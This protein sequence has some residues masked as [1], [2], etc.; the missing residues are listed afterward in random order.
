[1]GTCQV[2]AAVARSCAVVYA[3]YTGRECMH[4]VL[5]GCDNKHSKLFACWMQLGSELHLSFVL[6]HAKR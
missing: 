4:A 3:Q 2:H 6:L 5:T 1:M